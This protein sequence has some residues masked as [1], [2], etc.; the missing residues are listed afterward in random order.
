MALGGGVFVTQNKK[1]PGAYI[2][3]VSAS[4]AS[5]TLSDRGYVALPLELSWG[6]EGEVITLTS[7]D[8]IYNSQKILGYAY[9][10]DELK[11]LRDVFKNAQTVYIYRTNKSAVKATCT[12]CD[13]KYAGTRGNA[14]T[15]VISK[16]VDEQEKFDVKTLLDLKVVDVQTAVTAITDLV[17]SDYV[18][19]KKSGDLAETAGT[20]LTGGD[21]GSVTTAEWQSALNALEAYSFNTLGVVSKDDNVKSLAIAWTKRMRDEVGVKFQTVVFNKDADDKAIIN[22]VTTLSGQS[23][24]PS[25][26][27]WTTGAQ[28]GCAVNKSCTNKVYDGE[29]TPDVKK[30]QDELTVCIDKGQFVFHKVG[31]DVRVLTDINSKVTVSEDEG[32]DF[33]SNQTIRVLDQIANDIAVLFN[34]KYLGAIQN[35]ASGRISLWNDITKHHQSLE[36][37]GAIE[38]FSTDDVTV[39]QGDTKKSVVVSDKVT[40]VNAMEI[41]YMTVVVS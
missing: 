2:N 24:D 28:G 11:G 12:Y 35:N 40:P 3:F 14:L 16:N 4:K 1:L 26:V 38:N 18:T 27:Y 22:V 5:A 21:N 15:I 9:S 7:E 13:A 25:M 36:R 29:F 6:A 34:T 10:A 8:F 37:L 33:K 30:T 23:D 41:L 19:W 32:E 39:T 17:D 31:D 20:P